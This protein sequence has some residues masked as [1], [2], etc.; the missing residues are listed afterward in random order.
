MFKKNNDYYLT[1]YCQTYNFADYVVDA[2]EGFVNQITDTIEIYTKDMVING[3]RY[4]SKTVM[5]ELK[6]LVF[7]FFSPLSQ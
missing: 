4:A 7:D 6:Y 2:L 1:V 5:S 3:V